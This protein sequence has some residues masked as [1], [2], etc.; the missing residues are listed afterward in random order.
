MP[1]SR[2]NLNRFKKAVR[3]MSSVNHP[4]EEL[5][6]AVIC[7][8]ATDWMNGTYAYSAQRFL[9]RTHNPWAEV[10]SLESFELRDLFLS[11]R[12]EEMKQWTQ[13]S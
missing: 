2:P 1:L 3:R 6:Y 11:L 13:I 9:M 10:I 12:Q 5:A 8:A 4:E 7:Q